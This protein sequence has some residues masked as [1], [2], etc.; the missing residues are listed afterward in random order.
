[1]KIY[2]HDYLVLGQ[3]KLKINY[4]VLQKW[5]SVLVL[6]VAIVD[7]KFG[8]FWLL[9]LLLTLIVIVV[10]VLWIEN[11]AWGLV[12]VGTGSTH[13]KVQVRIGS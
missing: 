8:L 11:R 6:V 4:Y 7:M 2:F 5:L 13:S 3:F 10:I 9:F 1:M 12:R